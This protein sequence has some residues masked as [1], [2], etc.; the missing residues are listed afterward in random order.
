[1]F[2]ITSKILMIACLALALTAGWFSYQLSTQKKLLVKTQS[3]LAVT[4]AVNKMNEGVISQLE[5]QKQLQDQTLL[6]LSQNK[7]EIDKLRKSMVSSLNK[8]IATN[9]DFRN[10]FATRLDIN[11]IRL[12]NESGAY[13]TVQTDKQ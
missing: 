3:E 5:E 8:V 10:W 7:E 13:A 12:Y 2:N 9:E 4:V 11:A 6:A 1:M